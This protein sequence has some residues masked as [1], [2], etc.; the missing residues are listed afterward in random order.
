MTTRC[1]RPSTAIA[2]TAWAAV[3]VYL[4]FAWPSLA[5]L[6]E[7]LGMVPPRLR[8]LVRVPSVAFP[9]LGLLAVIGLNLKDRFLRSSTAIIVDALFA[10]PPLTAIAFFAYPFLVPLE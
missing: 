10:A 1:K 8:W 2:A 4:A 5:A 6:L 3:C 9:A 7:T